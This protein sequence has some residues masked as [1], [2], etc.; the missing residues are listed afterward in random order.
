MAE[1]DDQAPKTVVPFT[2]LVG[3]AIAQQLNEF[4]GELVAAQLPD[5]LSALA[6]K[7]AAAMARD[8]KKEDA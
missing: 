4:Y 7:L 2:N 1:H 6:Q 5:D 3:F 8:R